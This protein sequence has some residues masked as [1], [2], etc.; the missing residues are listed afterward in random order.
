MWFP[1]GYT[2]FQNSRRL[3][4]RRLRPSGGAFGHWL[5]APRLNELAR[6]QIVAAQDGFLKLVVDAKS[7]QVLGVAA[8]GESAADL[9]SVGQTALIGELSCEAFVDTVF[10]FPTMAESYRVAA[11]DVLGQKSKLAAAA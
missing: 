4:K 10:N 6:G 5:G 2:R 7:L 1:W 3:G 9:V 8:L 11:L